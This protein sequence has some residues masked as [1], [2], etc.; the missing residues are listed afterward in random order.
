MSASFC[1]RCGSPRAA[2]GSECDVCADLAATTL[3]HE[4]LESQA[5][6]LFPRALEGQYEFRELLGSGA[7]AVVYSAVRL[8]D[9][10]LVAIKLLHRRNDADALRR[11]QQEA[12]LLVKLRDDH[13]VRVFEHGEAEGRPY[14]VMEQLTGGS[15]RRRIDDTGAVPLEEAV[16]LLVQCLQ[17][18]AACHQMG[19]IHRDLKPENVLLTTDGTAK[20]SDLGIAKSYANAE[21]F[22]ATNAVVGTPL[23]MSPEQLRG[24]PAGVSSDL[25][26]M[27][28][29]FVEMLTGKSARSQLASGGRPGEMALYLE[30]S[31]I[32]QLDGVPQAICALL[33]Q[34]L[35]PNKADRPGSARAFA[36]ALRA[37]RARRRIGA[38]R[39]SALGLWGAA[40]LALALMVAL[41]PLMVKP[42]DA[43]PRV[44][45][46]PEGSRLARTIRE[47]RSDGRWDEAEKL[48]KST[49]QR[50][51]EDPVI[52]EELLV[53]QLTRNRSDEPKA[54]NELWKRLMGE[55]FPAAARSTAALSIQHNPGHLP[56]RLAQAQSLYYLGRHRVAEAQLRELM[57]IAP[58]AAEV[59]HELALL[60]YSVAR[61]LEC[62]EE[63]RQAIKLKPERVEYH[64][65]LAQVQGELGQMGAS[66][67]AWLEAA[68][69]APKSYPHR[70][71]AA[72]ALISRN[73]LP[74]AEHIARQAI[75][76]EPHQFGAYGALA[77]IFKRQHRYADQVAILQR[78]AR[79]A[80]DD[81][82]SHY[83]L[84]SAIEANE[85]VASAEQSL[86]QAV[87]KTPL[88]GPRI[89]LA[90][91]LHCHG[92]DPE[93]VEL[94]GAVARADL[95]N[96]NHVQNFM[97]FALECN[98]PE[99]A[100]RVGRAA[101][102]LQPYNP[103]LH[104]RIARALQVLGKDDEAL[105]SLRYLVERQP[106]Y[107]L[108]LRELADA[109][110]KKGQFAEAIG[111]Y[112]HV[113]NL[114][115]QDASTHRKL[116][117]ALTQA[118][119][120]SEG[121]AELAVADLL[122]TRDHARSEKAGSSRPH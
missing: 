77:E 16:R 90:V 115:S 72:T 48:A 4:R 50:Y 28:L 24:E 47:Y 60:H 105:V 65:K 74:E 13:V 82:T 55:G 25:Y 29:I 33:V 96:T 79:D 68:R 37:A 11:F 23:Y 2:E 111:Y 5:D 94:Y 121:M 75:P 18:L 15:L 38:H 108:F 83:A 85:S 30:P 46:S 53:I 22:T 26:A 31:R 54:M 91:W 6:R 89:A 80:S 98:S 35:S 51:P 106:D 10:Q 7:F 21:K 3:G 118:G 36:T 58:D 110:R 88:P 44:L 78:A 45:P 103:V 61:K 119:K 70:V 67:D 40:G 42:Q 59:R 19:V 104:R 27:G 116:A 99:V 114:D 76:L 84:A 64:T 120:V 109:L 69:L 8:K 102:A 86:R 32:R 71:Q 34:V 66:A 87:E 112:R 56:S 17:G 14:L 81:S 97:V 107:P 113:L 1:P 57:K 101:L 41:T 20:I 52:L 12:Q 63:L 62:I 9:Q 92:R 73:R 122:E 117:E 39:R 100:V 93:A 95:K 49:L 43:P